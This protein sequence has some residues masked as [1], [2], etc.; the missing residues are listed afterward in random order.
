MVGHNSL[1]AVSQTWSGVGGAM[2]WTN[3]SLTEL[4]LE[5]IRNWD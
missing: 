1:A 2:A 3:T 4:G 5:L